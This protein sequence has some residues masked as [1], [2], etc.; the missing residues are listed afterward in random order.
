MADT[1]LGPATV[2]AGRFVLE[3]LLDETDGARFWRA[4]DRVLA[5]NVAVHVLPDDDPRAS[6]LLD[7]ARASAL[8]TDGHLLRVLDAAATD[9]V[10]YVV[11]EWGSG[12]TLD[13]L[14]AEGPLSP[15]RAAWVVKEVSAAIRTAHLNGVAHGRLL[16]ENVMVTEAG[17]VK[18]IGFAVDAVLRS[19][20]GRR[21]VTDGRPVTA[22]ESDVVNLAALLYAAL[23]GRWPGTEGSTVP[24]APSEHGRA[25]RPRRVR[26]G[27]PRPLDAICEQVLNPDSHPQ[28][29]PIDTAHEIHAALSDFIGDPGGSTSWGTQPSQEPTAVLDRDRL[30]P[31]ADPEATQAGTPVFLDQDGTG[32]MP[33]AQPARS[34]EPGQPEPPEEPE[35]AD[36]TGRPS[37]QPAT[38]AWRPLSHDDSPTPTTE[39]A[40]RSTPRVAGPSAGSLEGPLTGE[41]RSTGAGNGPVPPAWGPDADHE[42]PADDPGWAADGRDRA[43]PGRSWLRLAVVVAVVLVVVVAT[44]I[45]LNLGRGSGGGSGAAQPPPSPSAS[46]TPSGVRV[47]ISGVTDFDPLADPPEENP[48]LAKLAIDGKPGTAWHTVTYRGNPRLGGLKSGVGLLVDL[49]KRT[50]VGQVQL[51]LDG[52]PTSLDILAAPKARSAPTSTDGLTTAASAKDAGTDVRVTLRSRVTT[53]WLVVWLTSLPPAPGGYQGRIAEISARS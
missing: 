26:A 47:P 27:I 36:G 1:P 29:L 13:R 39:S 24:V 43:R 41:Q 17:S 12:V 7:A 31:A 32:W 10:V 48:G 34:A 42:P 25:L 44:V 33:A 52:R 38:T 3:D 37:S 19:P 30:E 6:Q 40:S 46:G 22:Q 16:P 5:R 2:L 11:N 23:V 18:L 15:R 49:G 28:A 21:T 50:T 35:N 53:R 8:V 4:T 20:D 51:R 14:V 45:A 9:G